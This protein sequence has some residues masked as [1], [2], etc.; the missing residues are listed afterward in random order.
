MNTDQRSFAKLLGVSQPVLSKWERGEY[1]PSALA[2][3]KIGDISG[4]D[5]LWWYE[6]AGPEFAERLK[7]LGAMNLRAKP[8]G[9]AL[10][11]EMRLRGLEAS[12]TLDR[13]LLTQVMEAIDKELKRKKLKL[14]VN[15]YAELVAVLYEHCAEL[16][17]FDA[18]VA[19]TLLKLA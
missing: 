2:L 8:Y 4:E 13:E 7:S 11:K 16:G 1:R 14:P 3:M 6:Q 18:A 19:K 15:K 10:P 9:G 5:R 17:A 12:P